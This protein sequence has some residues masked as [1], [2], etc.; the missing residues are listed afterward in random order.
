MAQQEKLTLEQA[1]EIARQKPLADG[2][3]ALQPRAMAF[4]ALAVEGLVDE[5]GNKISPFV[6]DEQLGIKR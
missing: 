5:E 6:T 1:I 4:Y 3:L 2:D